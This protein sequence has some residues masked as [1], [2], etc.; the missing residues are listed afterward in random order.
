MNSERPV[1]FLTLLSEKKLHLLTSS[2]KQEVIFVF[3]YNTRSDSCLGREEAI[4]SF[5]PEKYQGIFFCFAEELCIKHG[6]LFVPYHVL[7]LRLFPSCYGAGEG[8]YNFYFVLHV[9]QVKA[10]II[11]CFLRMSCA[12]F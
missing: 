3:A 5:L 11:F 6:E 9:F 10:V 2:V 7:E 8:I 1:Q 4:C 12:A